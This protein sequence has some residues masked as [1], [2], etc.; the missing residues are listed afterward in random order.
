MFTGGKLIF[1]LTDGLGY[2]VAMETDSLIVPAAEAVVRLADLSA[3]LATHFD[4]EQEIGE[5]IVAPQRHLSPKAKSLKRQ[6]E[7]DHSNI[8]KRLKFECEVHPRSV[9]QM[10]CETKSNHLAYNESSNKP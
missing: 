8:M 7:R 6:A 1:R 5:K 2:V 3:R 9:C 10:Y 4:R